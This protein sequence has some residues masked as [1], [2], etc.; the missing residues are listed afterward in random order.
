MAVSTL[1][2][3]TM[4]SQ[5]IYQDLATGTQYGTLNG[6]SQATLGTVRSFALSGA[7]TPISNA[8]GSSFA[9]GV[10][11]SPVKVQDTSEAIRFSF[12]A[13]ARTHQLQVVVVPP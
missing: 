2:S 6:W 3:N 8:R 7:I 1:L 11:T 13:E 9:I 5:A 12:D 4:P 10:S